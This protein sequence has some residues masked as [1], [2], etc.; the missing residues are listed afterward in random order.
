MSLAGHGA[1]RLE[2]TGNDSRQ[3][4]QFTFDGTPMQGF[5][6]EPVAVALLAA[7]VR[8][9][10]TMPESGERRGGYCFMGR[11]ADCLMVIDGQ[12]GVRACITPVR[13]GMEVST[14]IGVGET[15]DGVSS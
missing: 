10:R 6:G 2:R 14:Q 4:V 13:E 1:R 3:R 15:H 7:A 12:S 8:V 9:F 5:V 11:C